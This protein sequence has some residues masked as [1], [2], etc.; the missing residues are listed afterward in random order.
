MVRG[1]RILMCDTGA[2][3]PGNFTPD[4]QTEQTS[5]EKEEENLEG[6]ERIIFLQFLRKMVQRVPEDRKSAKELIED[7]WLVFN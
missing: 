4:I 5:L 1:Y 3:L 7:P 6:E 2:D